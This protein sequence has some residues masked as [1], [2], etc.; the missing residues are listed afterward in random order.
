MSSASGREGLWWRGAVVGACAGACTGLADFVRAQISSENELLRR[1]PTYAVR[2][3]AFYA[4]WFVVGGL[5]AALLA[6]L[7][8]M[9]RRALHLL[10]AVGSAFFFVAVWANV[11]WLPGF[12]TTPSLVADVVLLLV[13]AWWFR[14]R[15]RHTALDGLRLAPWLLLGATAVVGA[16]VLGSFLPPGGDGPAPDATSD[17]KAK[18]PNVLVYLCD[19]LRADHLRLHGYA[20]ETSPEIDAFAQ[21]ATTFADCRTVTSWTK[22]SVASL[23]TSLYPTVHACVEQREVLCP[24]AETMA[25]VFKA[26]G[27]RTAA[28][29]DNPFISPEFG[30]GQGFD[31][32]LCVRPSVVVN[33]TL[34][35]KALFMTRVMSLVGKP[36]GVG[37][38]VERGAATLH[39]E[40]LARFCT[41]KDDRP[42]FAYV[43]AMEPHLPYE[44]A[45]G[46]AETMGLPRDA[47]FERPPNYGGILPFEE[48]PR[49]GPGLVEKLVAQYD[50]EIRG[51]SREFGRL[52]DELKRRG[53]L[54]NTVV[55]FVSDHG[56]EF[57]EHKGWTHGHSLY[58]E[59]TWVPLVVRLP[60]SMGVA[61][62]IARGRKV[63]GVATLMD[64]FPT[65]V[66]VCGVRYPK[67]G[68]LCNGMSLAKQLASDAPSDASVPDRALL[69]EVTMTPVGIR[70]IREGAW[71]LVVAHDLTSE[72]TQLFNDAPG[73]IVRKDQADQQTV[74]V[75]RLRALLD[76]K[77]RLLE[78][79]KLKGGSRELDPETAERI[80]RIGYVGGK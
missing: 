66:D 75:A 4:G 43:Q 29:V 28:F 11:G 40:L 60:E 37:D 63:G 55:V 8:E 50:G 14:R 26:A 68:E 16:L 47:A 17:A 71:Q 30:F 70:S 21:D 54:E 3:V 38:H 46:D 32:F 27:W 24:E 73:S 76:E 77:F 1:E 10:I 80:R 52:L 62:K 6:C 58:K 64:V 34:L 51:F 41:T 42:W 13:A 57:Y 2:V 23:L 67:G 39:E 78:K 65:L 31:A 69:G 25:E 59:L 33:G 36:F 48:G 20:K 9:P 45:R 74:E 53:V 22:P 79:A 72:R 18:R 12:T 19:T 35:G 49:P 56:E 7:F 15:Y 61:P 5:I 44:P